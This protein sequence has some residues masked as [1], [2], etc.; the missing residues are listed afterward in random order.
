[1]KTALDSLNLSEASVLIEEVRKSFVST[2][3]G[4]LDALTGAVHSALS[5]DPSAC[6]AARELAHRLAGSCGTFGMSEL[7]NEARRLET[8]L[9]SKADANWASDVD[10]ALHR[11]LDAAMSPT[12]LLRSILPSTRPQ[13]VATKE[14]SLPVSSSHYPQPYGRWASV[15]VVL[16]IDKVQAR[17]SIQSMLQQFG[18]L[19]VIAET[20]CRFP[21]TPLAFLCT[22]EKARAVRKYYPKAD[23]IAVVDNPGLDER[24]A[25]VRIGC[26][27]TIS[28]D[29]DAPELGAAMERLVPLELESP[30]ILIVDDD[31]YVSQRTAIV[32]EQA[33]L[34]VTIL[35]DPR[36]LLERVAETRPHLVIM[37]MRLPDCS[38]LELAAVLRQDDRMVGVP[39]VF[40]T[41]ENQPARALEALEVG[42]DDFLVKPVEPARLV[43]VVLSRLERSRVLRSFMDHDG[44]TRLLSHARTLERLESEVLG[45]QRRNEPL[46]LAMLDLDHFKQV[47]DKYGHAT[48]DRVLRSLSTVLRRRA[49]RTDVI[50]RCGGEEFAII[51][52]GASGKD[53]CRLINERR[54]MFASLHFATPSGPMTCTFSAGVAELQRGDTS[55]TLWDR[56]DVALYDAK[57]AGR[58]RV[59]LASYILKEVDP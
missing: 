10:F 14:A 55:A 37:D 30:R 39:I 12:D 22:L 58:N 3:P 59:E 50:G 47:N 7:S 18:F 23:I 32:L 21:V 2:L 41:A 1:V 11:V 56:A 52:S 40:L 28:S 6:N 4:L 29:V 19:V 34:E 35:T 36:K 20:A 13:R 16:L 5:A 38:G 31:P 49:R 9:S 25:A 46:S 43:S 8:L 57:H 17:H 26:R 42:A 51:L 24:L 44:L 33:E 53:A 54:E 27:A 15:P 48:G 45:A